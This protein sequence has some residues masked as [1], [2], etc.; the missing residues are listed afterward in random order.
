MT[1]TIALD[2]KLRVC[3]KLRALTVGP[4][5]GQAI[6]CIHDETSVSSLFM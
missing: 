1:N 2:N 5:L 4:L 6:K 3:S